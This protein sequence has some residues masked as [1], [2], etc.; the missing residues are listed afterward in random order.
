MTKAMRVVIAALAAL[1]LIGSAP[2]LTANS[3]VHFETSGPELP[4]GG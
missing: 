2:F 4:E 3:R 1:L